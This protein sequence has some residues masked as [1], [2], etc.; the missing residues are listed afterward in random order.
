MASIVV[1]DVVTG[2]ILV[3]ASTPTFDPNDV[4]FRPDASLWRDLAR[5]RDHPFENRALRGLYPPG[6]TF[7]VC[8]ALAGLSAGVITPNET[9][10]CPGV[11][12]VGRA[13]FRCWSAHG[14]GIDVHEAIKQSCDVYFYETAKRMGIDTLAVTARKLGLGQIHDCGLAGQKKGIVPDPIWKRQALGSLGM[15]ARRLSRASARVSCIDAAPACR[16]DGAHCHRQGGRAPLWCRRRARPSPKLRR[17]STSIQPIWN[18][19]A[20]AWSAWST[21]RAAPPSARRSL[22]PTCRWPARPAPLK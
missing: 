10:S 15:A 3:M 7:K 14:G 22:F 5:T 11:Y 1:L 6:S 8:T 2:D 17:C 12:A 18:S 16:H 19:C 9:M 20:A 13:R 21:R 4:A